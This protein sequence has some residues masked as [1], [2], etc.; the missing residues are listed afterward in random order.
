MKWIKYLF[1]Y[2]K[3][4]MCCSGIWSV[5]P[6]PQLELEENNRKDQGIKEEK[7]IQKIQIKIC[8]NV[9]YFS[10]FRNIYIILLGLQHLILDTPLCDNKLPPR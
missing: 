1:T 8:K 9:T 10:Y 2:L 6:P 4:S 3:I 5:A 7:K